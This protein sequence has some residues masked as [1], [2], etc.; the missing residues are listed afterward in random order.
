MKIRVDPTELRSIHQLA[1]NLKEIPNY[2]K[3][4]E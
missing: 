2:K 1:A 3:N 4:Y